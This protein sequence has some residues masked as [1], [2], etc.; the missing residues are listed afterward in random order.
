MIPLFGGLVLLALIAGIA[1]SFLKRE[2]G[3][4]GCV[5]GVLV[6]GTVPLVPFLLIGIPLLFKMFSG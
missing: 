3:S 4:H 2:D 1:F 5:L 6:A